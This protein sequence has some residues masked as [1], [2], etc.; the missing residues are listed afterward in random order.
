MH[1]ETITLWGVIW[2]FANFCVFIY[3]LLKLLLIF[4]FYCLVRSISCTGDIIITLISC[5]GNHVRF[6]R[7]G[8]SVGEQR[9]YESRYTATRSIV[10]PHYVCTAQK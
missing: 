9:E 10:A 2:Y 4:L 7:H 5:Q 1:T 8:K 6:S 3:L